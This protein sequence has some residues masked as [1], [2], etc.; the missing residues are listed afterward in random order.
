MIKKEKYWDADPS[1]F[2]VLIKPELNTYGVNGC[3]SWGESNCGFEI[4][5]QIDVGT[6]RNTYPAVFIRAKYGRRTVTACYLKSKK[7][8]T[9][10]RGSWTVVTHISMLC[11][12]S[13]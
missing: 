10:G 9:N 1:D 12:L 4:F 5:L 13:E 3:Y 11:K 2:Q 6:W 7:A 8:V